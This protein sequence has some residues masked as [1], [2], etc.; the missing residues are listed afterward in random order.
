MDTRPE[1]DY[2]DEPPKELFIGHEEEP[3]SGQGCF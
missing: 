1:A 2:A 3:F